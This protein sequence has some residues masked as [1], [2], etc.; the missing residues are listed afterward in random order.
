MNMEEYTRAHAIL[1]IRGNPSAVYKTIGEGGHFPTLS[2]ALTWLSKQTPMDQIITGLTFTVTAGSN[3]VTCSSNPYTAGVRTGDMLRVPNDQVPA[4][5]GP[6]VH[7]YPILSSAFSPSTNTNVI[8]GT[9]I[10]S[11]TGSALPLQIWRPRR[12]VFELL[13]GQEHTADWDNTNILAGAN[14]TFVGHGEASPLLMT[15]PT[16]FTGIGAPYYGFLSAYQIS[17]YDGPW[18]TPGDLSVFTNYGEGMARITLEDQYWHLADSTVWA[19]KLPCAAFIGKNLNFYDVGDH[20]VLL[21]A[22]YIDIKGMTVTGY[23]WWELFTVS[24]GNNMDSTSHEKIIRDLT[25]HRQ[26]GQVD[27]SSGPMALFQVAG[28]GDTTNI[29]QLFVDGIHIV[30]EVSNAAGVAVKVSGNPG[31]SPLLPVTCEVTLRGGIVD[32]TAVAGSPPTYNVDIQVTDNGGRVWLENVRRLDKTNPTFS[33]TLV[34][35]VKIANP[36]FV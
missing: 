36:T 8:L 35:S 2:S 5:T 24:N 25:M 31:G 10:Q 34:G 1:G 9:A 32:H 11:R 27:E 15:S 33:E 26:P 16:A 23:R 12:Y 4:G 22:D 7:Y 21:G 30:D 29:F 19:G 6:T 14:V 28:R 18:L 17:C 3:I 13:P 20:G